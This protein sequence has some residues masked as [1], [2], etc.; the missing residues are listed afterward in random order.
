MERGGCVYI[1]TNRHYTTLYVGVT[2][3]LVARVQEHKSKKHPHSLCMT[4]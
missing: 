4:R 3:D 2:A 1:M